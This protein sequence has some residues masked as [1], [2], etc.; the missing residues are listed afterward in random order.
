MAKRVEKNQHQSADVAEALSE[1]VKGRNVEADYVRETLEAGLLSAVK[2]KYGQADNVTVK[3]DPKS[4]RISMSA[5]R[6]VVEELLDPGTEV[7]LEE[8][9]EKGLKGK[10]GDEVEVPIEIAEFGRNAIGLVKQV[11]VQKVREAERERVYAEYIGRVNEVVVGSVQQMDKGNVIVNLGR[12]EGVVPPKEQIPREKYR[13]GERLRC[14]VLDVQKAAKGPPV[15]LS[16]A[17][18]DLL[19]RLFELEVPEIFE[20]I[21]E[22]K[23]VAREPG[24]RSK[25]AVSSAD[26]R[27]DPVGACVGIR[28][29]RVQSIVRE[30]AGERI[31]VIAWS[32]NPEVYVT[33]AL[34]PAKVLNLNANEAENEMTV[35][36]AD[37]QLSL[38]I[39]KQGQNARLAAKL[40]GW[41]INVLAESE[42]EAERKRRQKERIPLFS[43]EGL[44]DVMAKKLMEMG[45]E[46]VQLLAAAKADDLMEIEGVGPKKAEK[47]IASAKEFMEELKKRPAEEESEEEEEEELDTESEEIEEEEEDE[48]TEEK[49]EEETADSG[50]EKNEEKEET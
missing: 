17:H 27:I 34:A 36:V 28:G 41:K 5:R 38:A 50:Q 22:I 1:V 35:V 21:I 8:L 39:G 4:G 11:L 42:H 15:I 37:D 30:L 43:L 3:V 14:L 9:S 40:T 49:K 31:D 33:R 45:Y 24:E 26:E 12:A 20:K 19:R 23:S 13:L 46:T 48:E 44:S 16:R 32:A 2:K 10:L 6:K 25:I 7:T 29:I 47:L 18:P